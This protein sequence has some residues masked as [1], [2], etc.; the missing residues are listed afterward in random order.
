MQHR[1]SYLTLLN[2]YI[3]YPNSLTLHAILYVTLTLQYSLYLIPFH[4]S[5]YFVYIAIVYLTLIYPTNILLCPTSEYRPTFVMLPYLCPTLPY[6]T[7]PYF[8][9]HCNTYPYLT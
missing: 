3:F 9:Y 7:L 4:P 2:V 1:L 8:T 6:C 5:S